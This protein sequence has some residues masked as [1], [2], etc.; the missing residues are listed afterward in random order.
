M[1]RFWWYSREASVLR[2]FFPRGAAPFCSSEALPGWQIFWIWAA[3][4]PCAVAVV[5][6]VPALRAQ[7]NIPGL[8]L[9]PCSVPSASTTSGIATSVTRGVGRLWAR[10]VPVSLW[11]LPSQGTGTAP[12]GPSC[13]GGPREGL[14]RV[15]FPH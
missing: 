3:E 13:G 6:G 8:L 10:Q 5:G 12:A 7:S 4:G 9:V 14:G 1:S 11:I 2:N 15:C